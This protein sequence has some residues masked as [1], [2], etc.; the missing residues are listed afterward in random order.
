MGFYLLLRAK[1][2]IIG[3]YLIKNCL[4]DFADMFLREDICLLNDNSN[5]DY[6]YIIHYNKRTTD[7]AIIIIII[8]NSTHTH[9][10]KKFECDIC[11]F[12]MSYLKRKI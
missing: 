3:M 10:Q 12:I 9:A 11:T 6:I 5:T 2:G 7:A 8:I 4:I 1:L